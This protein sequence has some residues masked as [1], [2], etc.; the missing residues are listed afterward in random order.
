MKN[1]VWKTYGPGDEWTAHWFNFTDHGTTHLA[2]D[3][4]IT[5]EVTR[6]VHEVVKHGAGAASLTALLDEAGRY[7][8]IHI[9]AGTDLTKTLERYTN[10]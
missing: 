3:G 4:T 10:A 7:A 6:D 5:E 1:L 2:Q 9:I 8:H